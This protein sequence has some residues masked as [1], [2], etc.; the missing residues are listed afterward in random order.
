M[1]SA[2]LGV[3]LCLLLFLCMWASGLTQGTLPASC[4]SCVFGPQQYTRSTSTPR[5]E[6]SVFAADPEAD[7]LIDIDD[8]ASQ[9]ADGSVTLNGAVVLA[10]RAAGEEGPRHLRRPIALHPQ[11]TLAVRLTGKPRSRL[12]VQILGGAKSIG[13]AGGTIRVPGGAVRLDIP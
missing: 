13:A 11:N 7:Y 5:T 3:G 8:L 2:R 6:T 10:P 12:V 9:G 4:P 1:S